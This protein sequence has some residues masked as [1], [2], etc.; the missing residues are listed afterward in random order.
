MDD[1]I[2]TRDG[3]I[4]SISI[5]CSQ[6]GE[7]TESVLRG[8]PGV[9]GMRVIVD[10]SQARGLLPSQQRGLRRA[11][12]MVASQIACDELNHSR[13]RPPT[14]SALERKPLTVPPVSQEAMVKAIR[15]C[16]R[17]DTG[18][19]LD[20][21]AHEALAQL[22]DETLL[23][24]FAEYA[25]MHSPWKFVEAVIK[26]IHTPTALRSLRLEIA[27]KLEECE[28]RCRV[29]P[30]PHDPKKDHRQEDEINC[31]K[32]IT[33]IDTQLAK[34]PTDPDWLVSLIQMAEA[35]GQQVG[36]QMRARLAEFT[37]ETALVR[38]AEAA[39]A[40]CSWNFVQ[41]VILRINGA[42]ALKELR[43]YIATAQE[44]EAERGKII[45]RGQHGK[46]NLF[47]ANCTLALKVIDHKY[48]I[49]EVSERVAA[50]R[51]A[52]K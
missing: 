13:P 36:Q 18:D 50:A 51:A 9:A 15:A 47:E 4:F 17:T 49:A 1:L 25:V 22:T 29:I 30:L 40:T 8:D 11:L 2:P 38:I 32:A 46:L 23:L 27:A 14:L 33:L 42:A 43:E 44:Q 31:E 5:A 3:D 35:E 24:E 37:E 41:D 12:M 21:L 39:L 48:S 16:Q 19:D 6:T 26:R 28:E 52:K 10:L 7:C 34:P 20:Q 45:E